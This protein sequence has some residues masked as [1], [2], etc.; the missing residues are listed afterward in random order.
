MLTFITRMFRDKYKSLII[1]CLSAVL[2]LEMF[3]AMFPMMNE[4]SEYFDQM[5][6]TMP[7]ELFKAFNLDQASMSLSSLESFLF[8]KRACANI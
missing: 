8:S 5:L 6:Q 1:Y 4:M 2:F 3:V 7:A